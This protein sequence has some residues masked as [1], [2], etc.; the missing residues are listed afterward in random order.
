[1]FLLNSW[2]IDEKVARYEGQPVLGQAATILAALRDLVDAHSDGWAYWRKPAAAA[3]QLQQLLQ[4]GVATPAELR[5]ALR[6]IKSFCTRESRYFPADELAA[7]RQLL[8]GAA[9]AESR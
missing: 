8:A 5:Q 9:A 6:P 3:R 2:E 4:A 7:F 1:M